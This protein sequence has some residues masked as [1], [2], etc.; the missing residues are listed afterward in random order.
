MFSDVS[1]LKSYIQ[2]INPRDKACFQYTQG[3]WRVATVV[4]GTSSGL[5]SLV[6]S[7]FIGNTAGIPLNLGASLFTNLPENLS[8]FLYSIPP[9]D[10]QFYIFSIPSIDLPAIIRGCIQQSKNLGALAKGYVHESTKNLGSHLYSIEYKILQSYISGVGPLNLRVAIKVFYKSSKDMLGL[11]LGESS[12][13]VNLSANLFSITPKDIEASVYGVPPTNLPAS[14]YG[15]PSENLKAYIRI[16]SKG[17]KDFKTIIRGVA[18]AEVDLQALLHP[19]YIDNIPATIFAVEPKDMLSAIKGYKRAVHSNLS[20]IVLGAVFGET[21]GLDASII[22]VSPRDL[23]AGLRGMRPSQKNLLARLKGWDRGDLSLIGILQ[24][25]VENDILA[26]INI[27]RPRNLGAHLKVWPYRNLKGYIQGYAASELSA[28]VILVLISELPAYIGA[29]SPANLI[30]CI[31]SWSFG[32]TSNLSAS[33]YAWHVADFG[34]II[35]RYFYRGFTSVAATINCVPLYNLNAALVGWAERNLSAQIVCYM[36]P[37]YLRA[38]INAHGGYKNL[39]LTV[40]AASGVQQISNLYASLSG[41]QCADLSSTISSI[42]ATNIAASITSVGGAKDINATIKVKTI[43]FNEFYKFSTVNTADLRAYIGYSLC[44]L[45]T[46]RSAYAT[47][48]SMIHSVPTYNLGAT[49]D[50]YKVSFSGSK[51]LGVFLSY[52]NKY[53]IFSN[54]ASF[55]FVTAVSDAVRPNPAFAK[56]SLNITFKIINGL[57]NLSSTLTSQPHNSSLRAKIR[58]KLLIVHGRA[59][60][61][62]LTEELVEI[63]EYIKRWSANVDVY[64]NSE[65]PMYYT[66][67]RVFS[68]EYGKPIFSILFKRKAASGIEYTY[69]LNHDMFFGSTDAAVRYG[70]LKVAGRMG[71][72]GL[73]ATIQPIVKSLRLNVKIKGKEREPR[74]LDSPFTYL[75]SGS[76]SFIGTCINHIMYKS[77]TNIFGGIQDMTSSISAVPN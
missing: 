20:A 74:Y 76:L 67:G 16:F 15:I 57:C 45:R 3:P 66:S 22:A 64:L 19:I 4:V 8:A 50:G 46:P 56:N 1:E 10:L 18:S 21:T 63:D 5:K 75:K 25:Y 39:S 43:I 44:T 33:C 37:G 58:S 68:K 54:F 26:H 55:K 27:I 60:N 70:L 47:L 52:T 36:P 59:V 7:V 17:S 77:K 65:S 24:P 29:H 9:K 41:W 53:S 62:V 6:R 13:A 38:T 32:N 2:A 12:G 69:N 34:A 61:K 72:F 11:L 51:G 40:R 49:I 30:G 23:L 42:V 35:S 71:M 48:T 28:S 73:Q 14:L 31:K